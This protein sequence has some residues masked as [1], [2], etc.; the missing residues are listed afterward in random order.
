M[1]ENIFH[2]V[3]VYHIFFIH[4]TVDGHLVYFHVL[5]CNCYE[6]WGT[7]F[8]LSYSFLWIYVQEWDCWTMWQL[9][10]LRTLHTLSIG[11]QGLI[12]MDCLIH[13]LSPWE[14]LPEGCHWW[15]EMQGLYR[16]IYLIFSFFFWLCWVFVV[17]HR[18]S[19][20]VTQGLLI[21]VAFL[22]VEPTLWGMWA[23]VVG[24]HGPSCPV[25]CGIFPDQGSDWCPLHR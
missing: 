21:A 9:N 15:I 11:W 8:S 14:Q 17:A 12:C 6:H 1:A 4:S 18:L 20:V 3:Y 5:G 16:S 2:C 13:F 23:S 25:A 7:G 24:A 10:F 19:L 22:V